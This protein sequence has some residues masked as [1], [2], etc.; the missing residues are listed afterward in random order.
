M[1]E[2][3]ILSASQAASCAIGAHAGQVPSGSDMYLLHDMREVELKADAVLDLLRRRGALDGS[4]DGGSPS[5]GI[6][7]QS[8]RDLDARLFL[9][10]DDETV[11]SQPRR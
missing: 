2:N 4:E 1:S 8:L 9:P 7:I 6:V 11:R 5:L 10:R 3:K